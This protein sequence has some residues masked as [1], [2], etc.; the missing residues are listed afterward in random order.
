MSRLSKSLRKNAVCYA[1]VAPFIILF[2]LFTVLPVIGSMVLSFTDYNIVQSPHFVGVKNFVTLFFNDEIFIKALVNTLTMALIIGPFSYI[3]ALLLAWL[4]NE[5]SRGMR[6]LLVFL[7][8]APSISGNAY[9]IWTL[10]FSGDQLGFVNAYLLRLGIVSTP[11]QWLTDTR[12][13][14]TLVLLVSMWVSMGVQF[15]SFVAA[16]QGLDKSLAEAGAV[17]G[18]HNRWQELWF[19][20][21]PQMKPQ[22]LFGAVISIS[23]GFSVGGVGAALAGIPSTDYAVHTLINHMDDYAGMRYEYGYACAIAAILFLMMLGFNQ[24]VGRFLKGVGT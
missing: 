15:L 19:I 6:T 21:L 24:V 14:M 4:L 17:D 13:M 2:F 20:I 10:L 8:Y 9:M 7:I 5:L 3:G 12:Y 1:Y 18:I 22:M 16:F 11:I 23:V